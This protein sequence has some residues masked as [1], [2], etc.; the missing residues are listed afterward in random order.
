MTEAS[1]QAL[2]ALRSV[3]N[4]QWYVVPLLVLVIYIYIAECSQKSWSAVLLGLGMWAAET[5]SEMLNA[6]VLPLT[7]R[8]ALWTAPGDSAFVIYVG[9]NIEI[10]FFFCISGLMVIKALPQD[11]RLR[12]CGVPNRLLIPG[13]MGALAVT[14][15]VLLNRAGLLVWEYT[16]WSWPHVWLIAVVYSGPWLLLAWLHD[17]LTLRTKAVTAAALVAAMV[18]C[19]L[20]FATWLGWI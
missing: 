16:W 4:L 15:E 7:G 11:P 8:S 2:A 10:A 20:V 14:V 18:L 17:R 3:D 13:A 1:Q 19:H 6:L 12:I 9:L 5:I